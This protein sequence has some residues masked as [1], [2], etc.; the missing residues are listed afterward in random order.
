M[1]PIKLLKSFLIRIL[2]YAC[3]MLVLYAIRRPHW[4]PL[5]LVW[6]GVFG[7]SESVVHTW[8]YA[9]T[10]KPVA[11]DVTYGVVMGAIFLILVAIAYMVSPKNL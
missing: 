9:V 8:R 4:D 3:T 6:I 11:K 5:S 7:V 10:G 1:G 2:A